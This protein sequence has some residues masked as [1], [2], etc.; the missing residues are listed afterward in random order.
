MKNLKVQLNWRVQSS[1]Q[2][3]FTV[4]AESIA[5]EDLQHLQLSRESLMPRDR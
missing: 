4:K 2:K 5:G 3:R 1:A